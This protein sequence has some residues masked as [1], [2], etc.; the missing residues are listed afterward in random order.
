[1][2]R[3]DSEHFAW[4]W[5]SLGIPV[6]RIPTRRNTSEPTPKLSDRCN[7]Y[8]DK[9]DPKLCAPTPVQLDRCPFCGVAPFKEEQIHGHYLCVVCRTVTVGCCN[10]EN[11]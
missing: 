4:L 3:G 7:I 6:D 8:G 10:G 11:G 2:D 1:M 9:P 5:R